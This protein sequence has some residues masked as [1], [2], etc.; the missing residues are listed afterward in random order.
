MSRK[1]NLRQYAKHRK[2]NPSSVQAAISSGR[3][4]A[5]KNG[6]K[7]EIDPDLADKEWEENTRDTGEYVDA[8]MMTR[9]RLNK[10]NAIAEI[11][12]MEMLQMKGELVSVSRVKAQA[13][14]LARKTRDAIL[15]IPSRISD[16]LTVE[17]DRFKIEQI[18]TTELTIALSELA[19]EVKIESGVR[20]QNPDDAKAGSESDCDPWGARPS[21]TSRKPPKRNSISER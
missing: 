11:R 13:F 17:T 9:A 14:E 20:G 18:L 15:N 6:S 3:I 2:V 21:D 19:R 16:Q 12:R 1:L 7:F 4:Q 5:K 10:E 8:T